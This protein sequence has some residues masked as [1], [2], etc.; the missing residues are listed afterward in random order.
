VRAAAGLAV[1]AGRREIFRVSSKRRNEWSARS[2]ANVRFLF[3]FPITLSRRAK[4]D[5]ADGLPVAGRFTAEPHA[6]C[7]IAAANWN[8]NKARAKSRCGQSQA[9]PAMAAWMPTEYT[10]ASTAGA[11]AVDSKRN[12]PMQRRRFLQIAAG[13]AVCP[14]CVS[15]RAHAEAGHWGYTGPQG[16]ANWGGLCATGN[17]QSPIDVRGAVA[18]ARCGSA[19]RNIDW[20]SSTFIIRASIA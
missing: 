4:G 12:R 19:R 20:S 5:G 1:A 17:R 9:A 10:M 7:Q 15:G 13:L 6:R 3:A 11:P 18:A 8:N 2:G 16:P 14:F